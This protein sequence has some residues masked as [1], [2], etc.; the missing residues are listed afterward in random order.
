MLHAD[1]RRAANSTVAF[2]DTCTDSA[3]NVSIA[4]IVVADTLA[5]HSGANITTDFIR[6]DPHRDDL[7]ER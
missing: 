3:A 1:R 6:A 7:C 5:N 4:N 2:T